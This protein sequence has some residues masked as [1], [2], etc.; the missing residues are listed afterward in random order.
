M[1]VTSASL[2]SGHRHSWAP[3]RQNPTGSSGYFLVWLVTL[4]SSFLVLVVMVSGTLPSSGQTR[5][6]LLTSL[7]ARVLEEWRGLAGIVPP[8]GHCGQQMTHI[9]SCF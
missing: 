1:P 8:S 3:E 6:L 2:G 9:L 7:Q 5:P 4:I